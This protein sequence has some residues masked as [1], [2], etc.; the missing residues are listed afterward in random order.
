MERPA[1]WEWELAFTAHVESRMEERAFSELELRA[2]L[3]DAREFTQGARRGRWIV[4]T[5]YAGQP[6]TVVLEPDQDEQVIYVV[7]AYRRET[8]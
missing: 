3:D 1:W 5:R 2:M 4:Q 8:T 6:W 7:T